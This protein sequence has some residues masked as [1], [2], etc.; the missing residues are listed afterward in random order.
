MPSRRQL[1]AIGGNG[2]DLN[3]LFLGPSR[4]PPVA[5]GCDRAAPS[6][7]HPDV[8]RGDPRVAAR[9]AR[10]IDVRARAIPKLASLRPPALLSALAEGMALVAEHVAALE[11]AAEAHKGPETPR[12]VEAIRMISDEEAGKFLILL[13]TARCAF[14]SN[15][16]KSSQLRRTAYHIAKGIYARAADIR[17]ADFAELLR[18]VD[19]LRRSHYLDGPND[20][21]WI[22][23]NEIEADREERLYVDYVETDD[24]DTWLTPQRFDDLGVPR[25]SSGAVELVGALARAGFCDARVLGVTANVWRDFTPTPETRWGE[26]E[27]RA[28]ETLE[29]IPA[30]AVSSDLCDGDVG[31]IR[32]SWTFP[33]YDVDVS[34]IDEDLEALRA[35]Q[36]NWDPD[37]RTLSDYY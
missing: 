8:L 36:R 11:R 37:G 23:R 32:A 33:L 6:V 9:C 14:A 25:H 4:L 31:R 19:G 24:G 2:F 3:P 22:F 27:Q 30:G 12:A 10:V 20:V 13:D 29:Q 5:T 26:N 1:V 21:D 18:F 17:P 7:L 35:R 34:R 16:V 15:A 28:L